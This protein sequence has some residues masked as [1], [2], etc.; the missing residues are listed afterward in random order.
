VPRWFDRAD[1]SIDAKEK[2]ISIYSNDV[3]FSSRVVE[4]LTRVS[5][6][7]AKI[8]ASNAEN[9]LLINW[10]L[11]TSEKSNPQKILLFLKPQAVDKSLIPWKANSQTLFS[12][13]SN[14]EELNNAIVVLFSVQ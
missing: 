5:K 7:N 12:S 3:C 6:R 8:Y 14:R 13:H 11:G 4:L 10:G 2:S 1:G 9:F